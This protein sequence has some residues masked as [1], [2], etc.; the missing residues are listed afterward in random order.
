[1]DGASLKDIGMTFQMLGDEW[2]KVSVRSS[3]LITY[4]SG[5]H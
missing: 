1:M 5:F 4:T 3:S 2:E